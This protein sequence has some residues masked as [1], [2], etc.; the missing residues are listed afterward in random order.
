MKRVFITGD[1]HGDIE[2]EKITRWKK[3]ADDLDRSDLLIVCGDMGFFWDGAG[4]DRYIKRY[5]EQQPFTV[6]WIDGNHENFDILDKQPTM[7]KWDGRVQQCGENIYHLCRGEI[8][9]F[10]GKTF[11]CFGGATSHD[12]LRRKEGLTWWSREIPSIEEMKNGCDHLMGVGNEVDYM[13]THCADLFTQ[14]MIDPSYESDELIEY[15]TNLSNT[16]I[17]NKTWF[18]GH[19]HLDRPMPNGVRLIYQ[20]IIQLI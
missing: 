10:Y 1:M 2:I 8:Y 4:Y 11:F 6:L 20:D 12:K 14:R 16:V 18:M 9:N 17:W 7:T 15:F 5:W 13:I 19:Y 3:T